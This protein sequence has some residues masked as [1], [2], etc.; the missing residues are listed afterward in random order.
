MGWGNCFRCCGDSYRPCVAYYSVAL[1]SD[2]HYFAGNHRLPVKC[3]FFCP[4]LKL[5]D[6]NLALLPSIINCSFRIR[7]NFGDWQSYFLRHTF[8]VCAFSAD[9]LS[10][11]E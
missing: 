10:M 1:A 7:Q 5:I 11:D 3:V 9:A 6:K 8:F 4:C 2:A